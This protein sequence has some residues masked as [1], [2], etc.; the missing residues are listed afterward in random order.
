MPDLET[1]KVEVTPFKQFFISVLTRDIEIIDTIPEF[2]D[3]SIDGAE[4]VNGGGDLS[5]FEV[6]LSIGPNEL[7]IVDNCGGIPQDRAKN[8]SL[9]HI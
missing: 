4:R 2:V 5:E 7:R 9:I 3:N 8:L 1:E 6:D